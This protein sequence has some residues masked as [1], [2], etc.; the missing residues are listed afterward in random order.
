MDRARPTQAK[1]FASL[2]HMSQYIKLSFVRVTIVTGPI[3]VAL[4]FVLLAL[5]D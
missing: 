4:I 2:S 3:L 1:L 5:S